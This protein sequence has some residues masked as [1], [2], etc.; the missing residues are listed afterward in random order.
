MSFG[1]WR[2]ADRQL[3][4]DV[5]E[6]FSAFILR[7][8]QTVLRS[9]ICPEDGGYGFVRKVKKKNWSRRQ[10]VPSQN[11][12]SQTYRDYSADP[13]FTRMNDKSVRKWAQVCGLLQKEVFLI[14]HS[15]SHRRLE[16][17]GED[18]L[19]PCVYETRTV[20]LRSFR[21]RPLGKPRRTE[22]LKH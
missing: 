20:P 9:L 18:K 8:V 22:I 4:T 7:I 2:S 12:L 10:S 13:I 15:H 6:K 3:P 17:Q 11:R 19:F 1:I 21:Q 5:S 14:L 16:C